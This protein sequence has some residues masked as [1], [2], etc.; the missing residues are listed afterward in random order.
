LT[1]WGKPKVGVDTE[2]DPMSGYQGQLA[3]GPHQ[4][5]EGQVCWFT[6]GP[7]KIMV[8]AVGSTLWGHAGCPFP[9][10]LPE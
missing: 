2:V 8:V 3:V 4:A 5:D 6:P 1:V 10:T 9:T 7:T